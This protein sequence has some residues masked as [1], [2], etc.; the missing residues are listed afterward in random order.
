MALINNLGLATAAT[1]TQQRNVADTSAEICD[2]NDREA[3]SAQQ[4]GANYK[5]KSLNATWRHCASHVAQIGCNSISAGT[6]CDSVAPSEQRKINTSQSQT[7]AADC[8]INSYLCDVATFNDLLR[9]RRCNTFHIQI[10]ARPR[11]MPVRRR[12]QSTFAVFAATN[13]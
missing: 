7:F 3:H 6:D 5:S 9:A 12:S 8:E 4:S 10:D 11:E 13:I 2:K 1:P